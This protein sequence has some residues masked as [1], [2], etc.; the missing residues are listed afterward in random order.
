MSAGVGPE[1]LTV[2]SPDEDDLQWTVMGDLREVVN[3]DHES[4]NYIVGD[5]LRAEGFTDLDPEFSCFFGYANN[6]ADA[7]ALADAAMRVALGLTVLVT[8]VTTS[9]VVTTVP[10]APLYGEPGFSEA[11][12]RRFNT[13]RE[14]LTEAYHTLF[15]IKDAT[16]PGT[17]N[18]KLRYDCYEAIAA[19]GKVMRTLGHPVPER[20]DGTGQ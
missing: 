4:T 8:P 3:F 14:S 6:E 16:Q 9:S 1:T 12:P 15:D 19:L 20:F 13:E 10:N 5:A 17:G 18:G 7:Q 2:V 11:T